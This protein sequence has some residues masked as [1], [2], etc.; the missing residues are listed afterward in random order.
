M[1]LIVPRQSVPDI[2]IYAEGHTSAES[3]VKMSSTERWAQ[4]RGLSVGSTIQAT[5][6]AVFLASGLL[7]AERSSA[8]GAEEE[9]SLGGAPNAA[10]AVYG[11]GIYGID[12]QGK[13][14]VRQPDPP[15]ACWVTDQTSCSAR[16]CTGSSITLATTAP[17]TG[18]GVSDLPGLRGESGH[19]GDSE[20]LWRRDGPRYRSS[21][22]RIRS[23]GTGLWRA[24]S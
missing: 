9:T 18:G 20:V 21:T 7:R 22:L 3:S 2:T 17:R 1:R 13:V 11:Q 14:H 15:P 5:P 10:C 19:E 12:R 4:T 23:S 6:R 16:A 24:P 8:D